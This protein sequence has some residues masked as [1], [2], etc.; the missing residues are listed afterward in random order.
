MATRAP[1]C[2][3]RA[4]RPGR[5]RQA[6]SVTCHTPNSASGARRIFNNGTDVFNYNPEV[7]EVTISSYDPEESE[8]NLGNVY[9]LYKKGFKYILSE[10]TAS[11][12]RIIEL[13]PESRDESYFKIKMTI[14]PKDELEAF[15]VFERTGNK[16]IYSINS[17][18]PVN[19]SEINHLNIWV[20]IGVKG[21][22]AI[23]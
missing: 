13:D 11:G 3:R 5:R 10:K 21:E 8:I 18:N 9:D 17:F 6:R 16:Y 7:K 15:T 19:L 1:S 20:F 12:N 23:W 22:V 2:Q 14:N 4:L